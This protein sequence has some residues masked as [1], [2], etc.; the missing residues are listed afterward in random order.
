M[1]R[2]VTKQPWQE[3]TFYDNLAAASDALGFENIG[4]AWGLAGIHYQSTA[5]REQLLHALTRVPPNEA[6]DQSA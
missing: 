5:D 1:I 2:D 6:G 3:G 4:I